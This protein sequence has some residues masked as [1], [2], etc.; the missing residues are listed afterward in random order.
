MTVDE[1]RT[2]S[3]I[4]SIN[5]KMK[6]QTDIDWEERTFRMYMAIAPHLRMLDEKEILKRAIALIET[7]KTL[8]SYEIN[9]R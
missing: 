2:M 8:M 4:Q 7:Y 3:A 6:D 5:R 1:Q 9:N